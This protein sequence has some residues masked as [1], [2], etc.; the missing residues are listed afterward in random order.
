[1]VLEVSSVPID[2][3]A[4][5]EQGVTLSCDVELSGKIEKLY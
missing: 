4:A 3:Q 2:L 5:I 1:M